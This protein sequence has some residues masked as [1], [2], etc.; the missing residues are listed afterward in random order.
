MRV[1]GSDSWYPSLTL[2]LWIPLLL[3][4]F[5][6]TLYFLPGSDP[7][8]RID[9]P[10][11]PGTRLFTS[12]TLRL[13]W[14]PG[15]GLVPPVLLPSMGSPHCTQNTSTAFRHLMLPDEEAQSAQPDWH[16]WQWCTGPAV[17]VMRA[18]PASIPV[19]LLSCQPDWQSGRSDGPCS[20]RDSL[21]LTALKWLHLTL[22]QFGHV[23]Q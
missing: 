1:C 17:P 15:L 12:V 9:L 16:P 6:L 23:C 10:V 4:R 11:W 3:S 22:Q 18:F 5:H 8:Q 19:G 7:D 20:Q 14:W 21:G 13:T 2:S